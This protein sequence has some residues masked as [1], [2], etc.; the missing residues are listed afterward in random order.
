MGFRF[1][2]CEGYWE[3]REVDWEGGGQG[4]VEP[5]GLPAGQW[6]VEPWEVPA[7]QGAVVAWWVPGGRQLC[8]D[9]W[10]G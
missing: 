2:S 10:C 8:H 6:E 4:V 9:Y 7:G 3:V 1:A 5:W